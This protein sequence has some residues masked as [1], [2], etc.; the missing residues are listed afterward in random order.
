MSTFSL[1]ASQ[2]FSGIE[3]SIPSNLTQ[4]QLLTFRPFTTWLSTL[5]QSLSQQSQQSHPFHFDPYHLRSI[6]IQAVDFFGGQR[7]GFLKFKATV[8]NDNGEK[9]PGAVFMRGGSV[10]MLIILTPTD[11]KPNDGEE[12]VILTLQPRIAAG[13]LSF[14]EL[15]AGML[16][17]SGTFAGAA[18]KE[19]EEEPGH[20]IREDEIVDMTELAVDALTPRE[21]ESGTE[22][23]LQKASYPSP[24]GSDE[25]I[26]I[27]M[28]RKQMKREEIN[29]LKGRLTGLREHGEKITLRVVRLKDL[30]KV[31]ARDGKTLVAVA[32]LE[33]L[34]REG[35]L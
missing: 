7:L 8:S 2:P 34:R 27:L 16:D 9:I 30:W 13:S 32:L 26:P 29:G 31:G 25:F 35:K 6:G 24:G 10:A 4:Y 18:A 11:S 15:P 19:I 17:D 20:S 23:H 21:R 3:V 12:Y 22:E 5:S 1:P 14:V 28:A 33:G